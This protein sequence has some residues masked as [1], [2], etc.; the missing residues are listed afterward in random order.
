MPLEVV[1]V[2]TAVVSIADDAI[3]ASAAVHSGARGR[4]AACLPVLAGRLCKRWLRRR[5][6]GD[7]A[8]QAQRLESA[9]GPV[10]EWLPR[11]P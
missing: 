10:T 8:R 6:W 2:E 1:Y 4:A 11:T 3:A 7:G 9:S 5:E